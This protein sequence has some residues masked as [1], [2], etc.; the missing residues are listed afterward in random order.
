MTSLEDVLN[1]R[2]IH[3]DS[4]IYPVED[5]INEVSLALGKAGDNSN[6]ITIECLATNTN[7]EKV[8]SCDAD[9]HV[10][11]VNRMRL[12]ADEAFIAS[13]WPLL[14]DKLLLQALLHGIKT[15]NPPIGGIKNKED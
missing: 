4:T 15:F 10:A 6:I 5:D 2:L 12:P 13:L 11:L 7:G 8:F 1:I 9:F 3:I 14:R